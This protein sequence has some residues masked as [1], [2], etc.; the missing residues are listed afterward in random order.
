MDSP[1]ILNERL[2]TPGPEA[3]DDVN[4]CFTIATGFAACAS[5]VAAEKVLKRREPAPG[6]EQ[7]RPLGCFLDEIGG[8][9]FEGDQSARLQRV[10]VV[11]EGEC[12]AERMI[13]ILARTAAQ[14]A[15]SR[16]QKGLRPETPT[17]GMRFAAFSGKY[18][19]IRIPRSSLVCTR[20]FRDSCWFD[21]WY[22]DSCKSRPRSVP[23]LNDG[24]VA[25]LVAMTGR[26]VRPCDV[27]AERVEP[28]V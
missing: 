25:D 1:R 24:E 3:V 4:I 20:S 5:R 12:G 15:P 10:G 27:L 26:E 22:D 11:L 8:H 6:L 16:A 23:G 17:V 7:E 13:E 14:H 28:I 9:V 2:I 19:E 21:N 18:S